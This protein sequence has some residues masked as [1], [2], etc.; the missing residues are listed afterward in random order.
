METFSALLALYAGN[1]PVT[2][3]FPAQRPVTRSFDVFFDLRLNKRSS[4]HE[5][6]GLRRHR[7][8][9]LWRHCNVKY[10]NHYYVKASSLRVRLSQWRRMHG[11]RVFVSQVTGS[12]FNSF[13]KPT[14][15][16]TPKFHITGPLWGE[17][18]DN[19]W[20][21]FTKDKWCV[22]LFNPCHHVFSYGIHIVLSKFKC[23]FFLY[24]EEA[25]KRQQLYQ[26][27]GILWYIYQ[28]SNTTVLK[29][30]LVVPYI[31][32]I[33]GQAVF[34]PINVEYNALRKYFELKGP[35]FYHRMLSSSTI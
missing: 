34:K 31:S 13:L 10:Y 28:V 20:I 14:T 25:L 7:A 5:A 1:S 12:S 35:L 6:G 18:R 22:K 8:H 32:T 9:Y 23:I 30:V 16:E 21:P 11:R 33:Y 26:Y 17:S 3:E 19:Q 2:G 4:N 15:K 27:F 24:I 29:W